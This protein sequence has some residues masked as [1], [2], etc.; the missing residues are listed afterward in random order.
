MRLRRGA[1]KGFSLLEMIVLLVTTSILAAMMYTYFGRA[2][3]HGYVP[4]ASLQRSLD[5]STA[6]ENMTSDY[7]NW[8]GAA[9][10]PA[11]KANTVYQPGDRVRV[12]NGEFG[13]L[14]QCVEENG[15]SGP[16]PPAWINVP[17][18]IVPDGTT[19]WE[20]LPGELDGFLEKISR[21]ADGGG[22]GS[23]DGVVQDYEYGRYGIQYLGFIRF[24]GGEEQPAAPEDP[25]NS[26]KVALVN[27]DGERIST[28]FTTSY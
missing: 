3:T 15:E 17:G 5:L 24:S 20:V 18:A 28:L 22:S 27:G 1:Q 2:V 7:A 4:L 19:R 8:V 26:L 21:L 25:R 11:W 13:H 9:A 23:A 16:N 6:L 10:A 12:P 14:F